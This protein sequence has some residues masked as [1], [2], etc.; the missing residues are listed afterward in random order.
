MCYRSDGAFTIAFL[1]R[2]REQLLFTA[3]QAQ[4]GQQT[5]QAWKQFG[6]RAYR[7]RQLECT[8]MRSRLYQYSFSK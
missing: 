4:V 8:L 2:E 1:D 6:G 7:D 5:E 3:L